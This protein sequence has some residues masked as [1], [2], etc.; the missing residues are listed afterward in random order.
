[1]FPRSFN[2]KQDVD[3]PFSH[4]AIL[5]DR[6]TD[7]VVI[8]RNSSRFT[9]SMWPNETATKTYNSS[10]AMIRRWSTFRPT[11]RR[12]CGWRRGVSVRSLLGSERDTLAGS[13]GSAIHTPAHHWLADHRRTAPDTE[14]L[15]NTSN[16]SSNN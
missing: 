15:V 1:M 12:T 4:P 7:A 5:T 11:D 3:P 10:R 16:D 14:D 2:P 6:Q 8:D 9:H 13:S